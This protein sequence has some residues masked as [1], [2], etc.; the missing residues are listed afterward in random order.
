MRVRTKIEPYRVIVADPPWKFGDALG[1]RGAEAN[2]KPMPVEEICAFQLPRLAD[3]CVLFLWRVSSMQEEAL[4]VARA[5]GFDPTKG[6]LVWRKLTPKGKEHF[7]MGYIV[8]G[9]HES[10]LIATRGKPAVLNRRTRSIFSAPMP[11]AGKKYIHSAKPDEFFTIVRGLYAG[12]R[13]SIFDRFYRD[14]F[15]CLGDEVGKYGRAA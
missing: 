2:Y 9:S 8:R 1:K 13:V 6:E 14:G 10:C 15:T 5:W 12:P 7:G 3:D 11:R 4:R